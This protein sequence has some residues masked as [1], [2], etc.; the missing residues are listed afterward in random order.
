MKAPTT[1]PASGKVLGGF[2]SQQMPVV[3]EIA[4]KDKRIDVFGSVFNMNCTS[5]DQ[6]VT[7][8]GG[9]KLPISKNG[10]VDG[11]GVIPGD[12]PSAT[13]ITLS[14]GTDSITGKLNAKTGTFRGTWDLHLSFAVPNAPNDECDSGKVTFKARV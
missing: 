9:A 7:P 10:N 13:S 1:L 8:D 12:A 2:N 5:G 6:F 14:G 11:V 3:L 4:K